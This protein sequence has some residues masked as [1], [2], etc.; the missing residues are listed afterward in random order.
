MP[1]RK[2]GYYA[3]PA[4]GTA[5]DN[6][7]AAFATPT[8]SDVYGYTRASAEREK[9]A[10]LSELFANPNDPNFDRKNIAVGNYSPIQSF[11]AQDQNNST[12]RRGQDVTA[13]TSRDV[14]NI[15]N[16]GALARQFAQP[17]I[18]GD[19]QNA[20]L[21]DQTVAAT[22]LPRMFRGNVTVNPGQQATLPDGS[23]IAGA[24]KPMTN[25]EVAG[26]ILQSLPKNEQRAVALAPAGVSAIVGP[27]GSPTNV[28]T[29][30]SVGAQPYEKDTRQPQNANY[31][32]PDGRTG[33]ATMKD[34]KWFDTQS[35][36]E[37]PQG[38]QTYS[39]NLQGDKD[40]TGLGTGTKN[41]IDSML[42]DL[43]L[44]ESTSKSLRNIVQSNPAVQG[45]AGNIRG[46]VQDVLQAG[47]EVGQL[48]NVNMKKMEADIAAGRVDPAIA[49]KFANFDP[50]IPAAAMLETLLTAQVAKLLDPNGRISN[51][52]YQQVAKAIGAGGWTSNTAKTLATLDQVD[53]MI[54][55]RRAILAPVRPDAAK[56]GQAPAAAATPAP[57]AG[58]PVIRTWNPAT[59]ALE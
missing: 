31:K 56:I 13:G 58:A 7:A 32:T 44:T 41:N 26:A 46:T 48:F 23:V 22:G 12:T 30:D 51:D 11:Y 10:R 43:S 49:Q 28:F 39:A 53:K 19:G 36:A 3:D 20:F 38:I 6:L 21:P 40:Q 14:A 25:T 45:I 8:G 33:T 9:A 35:G 34:G 27:S 24:P 55:D 37:L 29:A 52:R 42:V 5:F 50:N 15:N 1:V 47:G 18:V 17:V 16:A 57:T 59:G 2:N 54:T 4:L